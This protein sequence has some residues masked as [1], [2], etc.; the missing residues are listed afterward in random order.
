MKIRQAI[1]ADL[2]AIFNIYDYARDFMKQ[3]GNPLQ[4]G[5]TYPEKEVILNDLAA[6]FLYVIEDDNSSL[7]G[8]FAFLPKGDS[9]YDNIDGKWLNDL[10][11]AAIHR[12]ASNGTQKGLFGQILAFCRQFSNNIKID[13][14]KQNLVMQHV[15]K[16]HGFI[17]CGTVFYDDISLLAFQF[18]NS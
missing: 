6:G 13:T 1:H 10:P 3:S 11:H 12:V 8:V 9:V 16:K 14:H 5:E 17:E 2:D 4:W 18:A 7:C 15:L